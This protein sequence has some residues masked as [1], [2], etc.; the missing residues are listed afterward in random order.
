MK[1]CITKWHN[2]QSSCIVVNYYQLIIKMKIWKKIFV[3]L[4]F[5]KN[6]QHESVS[7]L[8][9]KK[10]LWSKIAN[11]ANKLLKVLLS[12]SNLFIKS[13][14]LHYIFNGLNIAWHNLIYYSYFLFIKYITINIFL[15]MYSHVNLSW[16]IL[17]INVFDYLEPYSVFT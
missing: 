5:R 2:S 8:W 14:L 11:I 7:N 3:E 6:S 17:L 12:Y 15:V 10:V 16:T 13:I 1:V 4:D 9:N